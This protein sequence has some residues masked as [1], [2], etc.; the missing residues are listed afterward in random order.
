MN[1]LKVYWNQWNIAERII[2]INVLLF[3]LGNLLPYLFQ[4]SSNDLFYWFELSQHGAEFLTK[5]WTLLTYGFFHVSLSHLFWNM[6]LLWAAAKMFLNLFNTQY[7]I[8]VYFLGT[9]VGGFLYL[10]SYQLFPVFVGQN[11][12]LV[13]ASAAVMAILIFM[14]TYT[15]DQQVNVFFIRLKL[16]YLGVF[17]VFI[18]LVQI[19]SGNAGGHIA[20]LGGAYLG[21]LYARK[22]KTGKDMG[23]WFASIWLYLASLFKKSEKSPLKTV[24][25]K[26]QYTKKTPNN[27]TERQRKIDAILDKISRSGYESL[28]SDE[29][30]FL[31]KAGKES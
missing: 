6:I 26:K 5:P 20:H 16:W 8:N 17:L 18:D 28:S 3:L 9:L 10:M 21:F 12:A 15:P 27:K 11:S 22:L 19:P 31:F 14:C 7:F 25:R 30:D 1:S 13:G 24:Y 4:F 2:A 23:G 29:K